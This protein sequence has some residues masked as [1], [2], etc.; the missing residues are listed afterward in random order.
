MFHRPNQDPNKSNGLELDPRKVHFFP[1]I[2]INF[3]KIKAAQDS[4]LHPCSIFFIHHASA[5]NFRQYV[6]ILRKSGA[7]VVYVCK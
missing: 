6:V 1:C 2:K 3:K 5:E 4:F 7:N